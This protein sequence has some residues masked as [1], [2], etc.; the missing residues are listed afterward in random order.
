LRCCL[1]TCFCMLH[2]ASIRVYQQRLRAESSSGGNSSIP[3]LNIYPNAELFAAQRSCIKS[4]R[5][6]LELCRHCSCD[7]FR[8]N[9][10]SSLWRELP[11]INVFCNLALLRTSSHG[12]M[13][14]LLPESSDGSPG[15][16][17][18][19]VGENGCNR[20]YSRPTHHLQPGVTTQGP[21]KKQH[22]KVPPCR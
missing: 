4:K 1:A 16:M 8:S 17:N 13:C 2:L 3:K 20:R 21:N 15:R 7:S 11:K 14:W 12:W 18:R 19:T 9:Y 22:S 10:A 5:R 6:I